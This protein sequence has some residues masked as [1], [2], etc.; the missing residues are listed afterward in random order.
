[1]KIY[2]IIETGNDG[3][4]QSSEVIANEELANEILKRHRESKQAH[5]FNYNIEEHHL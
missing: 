1:M 5:L 2:I 4:Y 3:R